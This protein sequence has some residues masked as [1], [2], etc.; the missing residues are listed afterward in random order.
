LNEATLIRMRDTLSH[1]G[2]DGAGI[3][4]S[5]DGRA[6]LGHRRLSII[7]LSTTASQPM[8]NEDGT[9]WVVFNGEIYNH[10]E[11][12]REL[13]RT[14]RHR[15]RTDHSDTEVILHA[16]EEWGIDCIERFRGMFAIAL[17]DTRQKTLWLVRDRVG[18]KPLYYSQ[19]DGRLT[20]ASEIKAILADPAQPREVNTRALYH[21]LTFLTTPAPLTMF[22]GISKLPAG[23]WLKIDAEG[24]ETLTR[25]WNVWERV[26]P[27]TTQDEQELQGMILDELRTAVRLRKVSDVPVGVFLSGGVDSST[28]AM[29][30]AEDQSQAVKTFTIGYDAPYASYPSECPQARQMA[31]RIGAEHHERLVTLDDLLEF[32]PEMARL[33]DEPLADPVCV[34]VYYVSQLARQQGVIVCQAGE[35]ADELFCGYPQWRRFLQLDRANRLPVP[36]FLKKAGLRA[37]AM[38]GKGGS[39]YYEWLRRGAEDQPIFWGGAEVFTEHEKQQLVSRELSRELGEI[40]SFEVIEPIRRR[41]LEQAW[42]PS[43]LHW[44]TYLDLQLRL[45]ELLLMRIDKMSM[46]VGL[47]ARVPFLDHKFVELVLGIPTAAK[48]RDVQL[49]YLLKETVRPLIGS[50]VVDR[51]KQGFGVPILEWCIDRLGTRARQ[52][53]ERMS[54]ETGW[55][56][57]DAVAGLFERR[58]WQH[59]WSLLNLSLWWQAHWN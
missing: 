58:Q 40:S 15:W 21:Y 18:I 5:E 55:F 7:D 36:H 49:K 14:G 38:A 50:E 37:L 25:Y 30:F 4:M 20:F 1:R 12:R 13:E 6:G 53:I 9:L 2:P 16:F 19:R 3:W 28:N 8:T 52:E 22:A 45:P 27:R 41:F 42:E 32:L 59:V 47:E 23:C 17:W 10:A 46:G 57:A 11:V 34:P 39:P 51:P 24:R 33:Q 31:A 35:G 44:M 54:R 26:E 48:L 56:D 29:L 43:P